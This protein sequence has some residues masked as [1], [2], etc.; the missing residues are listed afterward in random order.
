MI[1]GRVCQ[2]AVVERHAVVIFPQAR[3]G[4]VEEFR[5]RWDPLSGRIPAHVTLVFP[6]TAPRDEQAL[7]L[8]LA[9]LV[10]A[11]IPFALSLSEV[12]VWEG[13]YLFLIAGQGREHLTRLHRA[14]YDG[15]FRHERRPGVFVPHMTIGRCPDPAQLA[16]A[17]EEAAQRNVRADGLTAALSVYRI[18][19]AGQRRRTLEVPLPGPAQRPG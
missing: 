1:A 9:A 16:A 3:L 17:A 8:E 19:D 13:E 15:P 6:V 10:D 14:L 18:S 4:D 12:R 7:A 2:H 5:R 11:F